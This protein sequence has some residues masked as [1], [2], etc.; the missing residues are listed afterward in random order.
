MKNSNYVVKTF[1]LLGFVSFIF[2][3]CASSDILEEGENTQTINNNGRYQITNSGGTE[4]S[5]FVMDTVTGEVKWFES[6]GRLIKTIQT[7]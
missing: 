1:A 7:Q 6:T 3:A 4:N 5:F 2:F